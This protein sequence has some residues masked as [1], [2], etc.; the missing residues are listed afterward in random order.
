MSNKKKSQSFEKEK[1]LKRVVDLLKVKG[2]MDAAEII[3]N[4]PDVNAL[5]LYHYLD[6]LVVSGNICRIRARGKRKNI[7]AYEFR[8]EYGAKNDMVSLA[9]SH[10]LHQITL[11]IAGHEN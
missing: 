5:T 3:L 10:P 6:A 11:M 2:A 9:L 4:L 1:K 8:N 7:R